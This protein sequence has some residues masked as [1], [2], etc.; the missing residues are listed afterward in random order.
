MVWLNVFCM[1]FSLWVALTLRFRKPGEHSRS[2]NIFWM[3]IGA[4]GFNLFITI[5]HFVLGWV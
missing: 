4:A 3:N 5:F 2:W 1:F